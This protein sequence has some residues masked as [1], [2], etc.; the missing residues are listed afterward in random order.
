MTDGNKWHAHVRSTLRRYF[1][2]RSAPRA[3]VSLLLVLAGFFGFLLSYASLRLG[4]DQ[5]WI[6]YPVALL[7][8]YALFLCLL[9]LWVEWERSRFNPKEAEIKALALEE[10]RSH[11]DSPL[12]RDRNTSWFDW[13]DVSHI[14]LDDGCLPA[15]LALL[16]F[17]FVT[18][19]AMTVAAMP[20]LLAEV[21]LDVF[22]VSVLYRRLRVAAQEHWLGTAV[23][24]TWWL[25]LITAGLL[26]LAGWCLES[27]APGSRSIGPA[28]EKIFR[29]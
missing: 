14:A 10:R 23:R 12:N 5:M 7:A 11:P 20:A 6:R 22:I 17:A 13:L 1:Q 25:A 24:K 21:F 18:V 3:I 4:L 26:A 15:L 9:R 2:K 29:G 8:G 28:L 19:L 27:A 16:L